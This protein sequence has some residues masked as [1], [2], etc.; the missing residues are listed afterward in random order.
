M[1]HGRAEAG[2][3]DGIVRDDAALIEK[4]R[5]RDGVAFQNQVKIV[6]ERQ[7]QRAVTQQPADKVE[8]ALVGA[9]AR[10]LAQAGQR[11]LRGFV[12]MFAQVRDE[13]SVM[14]LSKRHRTER[15]QGNKEKEGSRR[16]TA[17][18]AKRALSGACRWRQAWPAIPVARAF[19]DVILVMHEPGALAPVGRVLAKLIEMGVN[20]V[21]K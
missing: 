19:A 16:K 2:I 10:G 17:V 9:V 7:A 6:G 18:P 11:A 12:R 21:G 20:G 14:P 8:F 4:L 5:Q 13:Q 1:D 15:G 3:V